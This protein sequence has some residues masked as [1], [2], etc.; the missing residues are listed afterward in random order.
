[1][2]RLKMIIALLACCTLVGVAQNNTNAQSQAPV[3]SRPTV[4]IAP[5]VL[6][7]L[8]ESKTLPRYPEDALTKGI[9]GNVVFKI[10]VDQTGKIVRVEP[11]QGDPLLLAAGTDA[12][13]DYRFRP[14]VLD[15]NPVGVESQI[16]FRFTLSRRGDSTDGEVECMSALP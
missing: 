13:R 8:I 16:G 4:H 6:F 11:E 7:S 5:S 10:V 15:G 9:Q 3:T 2:L 1:M 14:Y 12:L